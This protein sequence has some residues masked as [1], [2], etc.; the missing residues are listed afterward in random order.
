MGSIDRFLQVVLSDEDFEIFYNMEKT[1][2]SLNS[3]GVAWCGLTMEQITRTTQA[4]LAHPLLQ[5]FALRQE[6]KRTVTVL[7][8]ICVWV[9]GFMRINLALIRCLEWVLYSAT[10][11]RDFQC[12]MR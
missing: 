11:S 7:C 2:P 1:L 5:K 8:T 4:V 6:L 12:A 3:F 10:T 9:T